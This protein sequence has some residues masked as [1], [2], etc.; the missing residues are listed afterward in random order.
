[1]DFD[2]SADQ[3]AF[4]GAVAQVLEKHK[5]PPQLPVPSFVHYNDSLDC[6]LSAN[7]YF[8]VA[9]QEGYGA[10]E[11]ALLVE[12][13]AKLPCAVE[14]SASAL[15]APKLLASVLPRPIAVICGELMQP[16]RFLPQARTA[17]ICA[18]QNVL[19]LDLAGIE[20]E[21]TSGVVAYPYGR[22]SKRPDLSKAKVL[23]DNAQSRLEHW[24]RVGITAEIAGAMQ[25]AVHF[26]SEYVTNRQQFGRPLGSL[27]AIQHRLATCAILS[28]QARWLALQAAWSGS[29]TDA[30]IALA[31]A[32][33][34]LPQI[35]YDTHQFNGALGLT[36]EHGLH[37]FT[38]RLRG[39]QQELGG[40]HEQAACVA[41]ALWGTSV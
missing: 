20:I 18:D 17:L 32:Q 11:A 12:A 1:M 23:S 39:L 8:D 24:W 2:L 37:W 15:A 29:P 27:Q 14:V 28:Q 5:T 16:V 40:I 31:N 25:A 6:D 26:T 21:E 7:E 4:I 22:F 10:L 41:D 19:V 38:Y 33:E 35:I 34:S 36:L 9:R 13:V 30:M 3:A